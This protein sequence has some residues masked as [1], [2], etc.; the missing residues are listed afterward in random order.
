MGEKK[1]RR[2]LSSSSIINHHWQHSP[3]LLYALFFISGLFILYAIVQMNTKLVVLYFLLAMVARGFTP[4]MI[5]VLSASLLGTLILLFY[6]VHVLKNF[7]TSIFEGVQNRNKKSNDK[8]NHPKGNKGSSKYEYNKPSPST[9]SKS[10]SATTSKGSKKSSDIDYFTTVNDSY[11]NLSN[12]LDSESMGKLTKDT[13][14]LV[15]NQKSLA[16]TMRSLAPLMENAQTLLQNFH[17]A[18]QT[19]DPTNAA[20]GL[21]ELSEK[22]NIP[23]K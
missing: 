10:S 7:S 15:Q 6:E 11:K 5:Y 4:N 20:A 1:S 21:A 16:E 3:P 8:D 12:I 13:Q 18:K 9:S 23:A 14:Q 2:R 19:Q 17:E 22:L